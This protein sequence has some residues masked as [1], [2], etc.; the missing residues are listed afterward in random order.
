MNVSFLIVGGP[1]HGKVMVKALGDDHDDLD[2]QSVTHEVDVMTPTGA[3]L[4]LGPGGRPQMQ[5]S[6][7]TYTARVLCIG[8]EQTPILAPA[9]WSNVRVIQSLG[10]SV[11][12][13]GMLAVAGESKQAEL[14]HR[15]Q[16]VRDP[17]V[18]ENLRR[19]RTGDDP[20]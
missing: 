17:Q 11:S 20:L 13:A 19:S 8:E 5:V 3:T 9:D 7:V 16:V 2:V 18:A 15:L 4:L 14:E 10:I 12:V 1:D 6:H